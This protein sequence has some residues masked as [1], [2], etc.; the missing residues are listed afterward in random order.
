MKLA[1]NLPR[2]RTL[3]CIGAFLLTVL[4]G[5]FFTTAPSYAQNQILTDSPPVEIAPGW[6][7]RWGDSPFN[8][9]GVP[10]WTY[11]KL[12]NSGWNSFKIPA[13]LAKPTGEKFLWLRVKLPSGNWE[14]PTLYLSAIPDGFQFY[15]DDRL[16]AKFAEIDSSGKLQ[17]IKDKLWRI[18]PI[19][20]DSQGKTLFV[21]L[22]AGERNS[23]AIGKP[24]NIEIGSLSGIFTE[25]FKTYFASFVVGLFFIIISSYPIL[26]A[27]KRKKIQAG[28]C[29]GLLA[30]SLG[31]FTTLNNEIFLLFF[32]SSNFYYR[33]VNIGS[34]LLIPVAVCAFYEQVFGPGYKFFIRRLWQIH[35]IYGMAALFLAGSQTI[36]WNYAISIG[37]ILM[38]VSISITFVT[39]L[40]N[41]LKGNFE[42]RLFTTGYAIFCV[43][44]LRDIFN[45]LGI[46][47]AGQP[48][49]QWGMVIF[50]I[51]LAFILERRFI[52]AGKRLQDYAKE[53]ET[54]N[55]TLQR[56]DKLKD[57]FL[58][59]TSHELR[60]PLNGIIG[61]A[62]SMI[63]GATGKL[64]SRQVNNLS[65]IVYSGK[66]LANLVNDILDFSKL[67]YNNIALQIKPVDMRAITDV[68]L[69]LSEPLIGKKS[70][71]LVNQIPTDVPTVDADENRVQQILQNLV[72]NAI[73]FSENGV[74]EVSA[75]VV[76]E[77]L[78]IAV[79]DTG[80]GIP[81][82]KLERIFESFEQADGSTARQYGGT[83]LGLA[84]TKQLVQL[85]GGEIRVES[86]VGKGSKFSFTLPLSQSQVERNESILPAVNLGE[87]PVTIDEAIVTAEIS[88]P[89]NG[90]YKILI[91]DDEPV[92][93]QVLVNHL[94]LQNYYLVQASNGLEA[95]AAIEN[96]FFPDLILLDVMM[97]KMTG[98]EVCKQI[99]QK[100]PPN[101]LPVVFLTAKEQASDLL[102]CFGSGANDYLTK[103]ISKNE[104][105]ARIKIHIQLAKVNIAYGRFVPH[106]FLRFLKKESIIDVNLGDQVQKEMTILFSDI[107][108]FTTL[109]ENMSPKE[110]FDFINSYLKRVGPVIR[111][112]NGFIDKYIGDAIMAL[113]PETAEDAVQAAINMQRQ[114]T[115]YN[116]HRQKS[117]Y[118]TIAIGV[119]LHT[120]NLMLGTIGEEQRMESTVISDAVNLA[121][122][123]EGLTKVYGA[124]IAISEQTLSR[125]DEPTK[126]NCRFLGRV[127]VKG[128][129]APVAVFEV[130]DAD[131]EH[132]IEL[133]TE[134]RGKF[135]E[136]VYLYH[137]Q[138]YSEACQIFHYLLQKNHQDKAVMYYVERCEELQSYGISQD[139]DGIETLNEK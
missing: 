111:N 26:S 32:N 24:K 48:I 76:N 108:S 44:C 4:L 51:F 86:V 131:P 112:H 69:A 136:G 81:D 96:G 64:T 11:D 49:Y 7:Y 42:A 97:P 83:G 63:D 3:L 101:Q 125:L 114:V 88:A 16:I 10:I 61:I 129:K 128:K 124:G 74:V 40:I 98:Y 12:S 57:E 90:D 25:I 92:N 133:K 135:E 30:L 15:L 80:I 6:Q 27:L 91:V 115:I 54:N 75:K 117:G 130:Y 38:I 138:K 137:Q 113:F 87:I 126:Y 20:P 132:S 52:E 67:K 107:R 68:V 28:F 50:I 123:M 118:P 139:G 55:A 121:S 84:V 41:A 34:L 119:G 43:T 134:T 33:Y 116:S 102:E 94:S 19:A 99:R 60:T 77:H 39:T 120:G 21:R 93:L 59:N 17:Q 100:Y 2:A 82:D 1:F 5:Q 109:S 127:R 106:E 65:M 78:E 58:A 122:R 18:I 66:R 9:R 70:L 37:F 36:A 105:L 110:N 8:N 46:I 62:E 85:H 22:Y 31:I 35:L 71:R 95:L 14:Y 29:F 45:G 103:P 72:G 13:K 79:S 53:L 89:N 23:I 47:Y 104:L 56:I 73:K